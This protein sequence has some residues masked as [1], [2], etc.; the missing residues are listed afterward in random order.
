MWLGILF[1]WLGVVKLSALPEGLFWPTANPAFEEGRDWREFIQVTASGRAQSGLF[2]CVRND[3][4]RFHEAIDI[5][6]VERDRHRRPMD[7]VFAAMDGIVRHVNRI[8]GHSGYGLYVVVEHSLNDFQFYTLYSHLRS[9]EEEWE[10]GDRIRGGEILGVVGN[11]A[12]GYRIPLSR[13]HLHFEIGLRLN[14]A[15]QLWYDRQ[16][17]GS[18]NEHGDFNGMNLVGWNPL[19]FFEWQ[20]GR[21]SVA[22]DRYFNE[23]PPAV[24][25]RVKTRAFPDILR[26]NPRLWVDGVDRNQLQ[27]WDITLSAWGLP[28]AFESLD[29]A[30]VAKIGYAGQVKIVRLNRERLAEFAC[31]SIVRENANGVR[32]GSGGKQI[33]E[34]L[35]TTK[36]PLEP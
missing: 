33:L 8:A 12:G 15:F 9:I 26:L 29:H 10:A 23:I 35:F 16:Q 5:G 20:K 19:E 17:F 22:V 7:K 11:T 14:S 3:G 27:G 4:N 31:R 6:V 21:R 18:A 36:T 1:L 13:A 32:L 24:V 28:L 25:V 34:L 30:G 2:G